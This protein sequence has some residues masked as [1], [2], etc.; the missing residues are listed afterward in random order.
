MRFLADFEPAPEVGPASRQFFWPRELG[1][2]GLSALNCRAPSAVERYC[3]RASNFRSGRWRRVSINQETFKRL[4]PVA[5]RI[6]YYDG[7]RIGKGVGD[8]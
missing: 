6:E 2:R 3:S 1:V 7:W 4:F 5:C 8:L